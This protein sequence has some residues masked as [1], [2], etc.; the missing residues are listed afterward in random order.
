MNG[1]EGGAAAAKQKAAARHPE[2]QTGRSEAPAKRPRPRDACEPPQA[3][4]KAPTTSVDI[5]RSALIELFQLPLPIVHHTTAPF[6][7]SHPPQAATKLAVH[8]PRLLSIPTSC[9]PLQSIPN[10]ANIARPRHSPIGRATNI[11]HCSESHGRRRYRWSKDWRRES[12][13]R[14]FEFAVTCS[15]QC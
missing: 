4:D 7:S 15:T 1:G 13:V 12:R 8:P 2:S 10:D 3:S 5:V 14:A 11:L 9:I 6:A